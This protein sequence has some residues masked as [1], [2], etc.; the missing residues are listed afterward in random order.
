MITAAQ[1]TDADLVVEIGRRDPH[2]ALS[3]A[4]AARA[5]LEDRASSR[6]AETR[7]PDPLMKAEAAADEFG[8][9]AGWVKV[10]CRAGRIEGATKKTGRWLFRRSAFLAFWRADD[11]SAVQGATESAAMK[12]PSARRRRR[13]AAG[14]LPMAMKVRI[15]TAIA[16][17]P[18]TS[19]EQLARQLDVGVTDVRTAMAQR[20][21]RPARKSA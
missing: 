10:Q 11:A 12:G 13:G 18:D 9:S 16:A 14:R 21:S 5:V 19:A 17:S 15:W 4:F 20:E 7:E 3:A 1:I 2:A 6:G 8:C